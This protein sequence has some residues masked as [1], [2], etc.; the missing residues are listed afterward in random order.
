M[1][2]MKMTV[3]KRSLTRRSLLTR[4]AVLGGAA[5]GAS[6]GTLFWPRRAPAIVTGD[7]MRPGMPQG[8]MSGDV[9][10]DG[11]VVWSRADRP[12]R[13]I[14]EYDTGESFANARRIV[15]PAALPENDF[16]ARVLLTDLPP[17]ERVFYRAGFEDLSD[18]KTVSEPLTGTFRTAPGQMQD[19]TIVWGGDTAG[20]GWGINLDWGGMKIHET[21]RAQNPD[22]FIHCGDYIYAD[23]PI[24]AEKK[25]AD[26]T[27]WKNLVIE[28]KAKVAETLAEFRGNY[29]YNLMDEH[30]RRLNAE[31][32]Q[33]VQWDDHETVN[34]WYPTEMLGE[35]EREKG[36]TEMSVPLL[37]ARAKRAF[38]EYTPVRLDPTDG[39]RI[40]RVINYGPA[41]DIF[42]LDM[43]SYRAANSANRQAAMGPET[44]FLGRRQAA[45]LK[46]GLL[47][48]KATWK[49][50]AADMPIGL[51]VPDGDAAFEAIA[52]GDGPA[53]GRELE[54]A[55]ILRFIKMNDIRNTVWLT[56]DVHYA[57][58]HYYD[59]NKAQFPDFLPFWEFVAG[60]LNAGSYGP[61]KLDNSFGPQVM[62]QKAPPEGQ[63]NLSPRAGLQFFGQVKIDGRSGGMTV[64]LRDADGT[65]LYKV[66]LDPEGE[67]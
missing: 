34:N 49:I 21:M 24:E 2:R 52:N 39:E 33:I 10:R 19:I 25:E 35:K 12:A 22:L 32:P 61:N 59:P 16:T 63:S 13:F 11:A 53:L 54:I 28:E 51:V 60:P 9:S 20:Q 23:G 65:E 15:G 27:I 7:T 29:K 58:A 26:G 17:G 56:A 14:V 3:G 44:E 36:Y 8:V 57:A 55:D 6:A 31:V 67:A 66:D 41:L 50:V 4:T 45:W 43:R 30:F 48:S 18:L 64:A 46:Q 38:L 47:M 1:A 42:V 5:L 62:F 40:Y 37:A